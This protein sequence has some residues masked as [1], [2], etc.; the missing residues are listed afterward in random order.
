VLSIG[1][2]KKLSKTV[3]KEDKTEE[4]KEEDKNL[5]E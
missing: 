5:E 4:I 2:S 3:L 1:D